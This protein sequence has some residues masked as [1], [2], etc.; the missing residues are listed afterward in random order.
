MNESLNSKFKII[1]VV[2]QLRFISVVWR[3]LLIQAQIQ[4][5]HCVCF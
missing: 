2:S 1:G 5:T 3:L 4:H